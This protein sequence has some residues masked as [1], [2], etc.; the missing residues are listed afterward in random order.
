MMNKWLTKSIEL[1]N[2]QSYYDFLED[3]YPFKPFDRRWIN[4]KYKDQLEKHFHD[5]NNNELLKLMLKCMPPSTEINK[6][7][8]LRAGIKDARLGF[9]KLYKKKDPENFDKILDLNSK[10]VNEIC[11][12]MYDEG[13]EKMFESMT[14]PKESSR[15]IGPDFKNWI[16]RGNLGLQP[17]NLNAFRNS[18]ENAILSGGD[19]EMIR[20]AKELGFDRNSDKGVDFLARFNGKYIIGEAKYLTTYGGTQDKS[21]KDAFLTFQNTHPNFI[22]IAILDGV[23]FIPANGRKSQYQMIMRNKNENIMSAFLLKNFLEKV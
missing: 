3:I 9:F 15:T 12:R 17:V 18:S 22:N 1:A 23:C 20:H 19:E 14:K 7:E 5:K 13:L 21:V 2:N 10:T 11:S 16:E 6:K 8:G 4:P